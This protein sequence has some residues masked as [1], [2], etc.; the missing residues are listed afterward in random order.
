MVHQTGTFTETDFPDGEVWDFSDFRTEPE[1][2]I[3]DMDDYEIII[4][5]VIFDW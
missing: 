2:V 1:D 3:Y 5:E 4:E